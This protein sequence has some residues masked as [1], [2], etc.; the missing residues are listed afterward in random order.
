MSHTDHEDLDV[1]LMLR[2]R[3]GDREAFGVL[4]DRHGGPLV[5]FIA[6][7]VPDRHLAEDLA[8]DVL[9]RALRAAPTYRPTA[10]FR[11]WLLTIA[12]NV[13]I[14][15]RRQAGR[16]T[17]AS[18][19]ASDDE[20]G[21]SARSRVPDDGGDPAA[22]VESAERCRLVREAVLSLPDRQRLA[23][24]LLRYEE[25]SYVAIGE[26]MGLSTMAVKSLLNR[27]K[28]TLKDKLAPR[29]RQGG[30]DLRSSTNTARPTI[31]GGDR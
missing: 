8:Q 22:P 4:V 19:E 17:H 20:A 14:N 28:D 7:T 23:V 5:R 11:T 13:C 24:I 12:T 30:F 16:H 6:R 1:R 27:A 26:V 18:L 10:R 15:R 21:A 2:A 25:M 31:A 9:L 3:G 29:L